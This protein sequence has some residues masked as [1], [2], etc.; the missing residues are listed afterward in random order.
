MAREFARSEEVAAV[1]QFHDT[2]DLDSPMV[3]SLAALFT[4]L[5]LTLFQQQSYSRIHPM[6]QMELL[7]HIDEKNLRSH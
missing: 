1:K 4:A 5:T 3:G 2:I 7:K 6:N